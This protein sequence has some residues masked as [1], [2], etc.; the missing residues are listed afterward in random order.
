MPHRSVGCAASGGS[1]QHGVAIPPET[2]GQDR[3][4]HDAFLHDVVDQNA[5]AATWGRLG[6]VVPE[7]RLPDL[8]RRSAREVLGP[9][10]KDVT[11]RWADAGPA[12]LGRRERAGRR[13][14]SAARRSG[15]RLGRRPPGKLRL[16]PRHSHR[17][18]PGSGL[19]L[20]ALGGISRGRSGQALP[21]SAEG[22]LERLAVPRS[23]LSSDAVWAIRGLTSE[24]SV[25]KEVPGFVGPDADYGGDVSERYQGGSKIPPTSAGWGSGSG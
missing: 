18:L 14:W 5:D 10:A 3:A 7:G 8:L 22:L 15:L 12:P 2:S 23:Q 4:H 21:V 13:P 9:V 6:L 19:A 25:D 1:L 24:P 16:A 11:P 17:D 20:P